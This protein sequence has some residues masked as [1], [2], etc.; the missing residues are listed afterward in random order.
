MIGDESEQCALQ[1]ASQRTPEEPL[2]C[3]QKGVDLYL[4]LW[5]IRPV[6][7][8]YKVDLVEVEQEISRPERGFCSSVARLV[9]AS[10]K[11]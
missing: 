4:K 1:T 8:A 6:A 9:R 11:V 7:V 10:E 2:D 5:R 3:G